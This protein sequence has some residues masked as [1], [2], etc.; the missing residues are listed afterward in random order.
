MRLAFFLLAVALIALP[1]AGDTVLGRIMEARQA[2]DLSVDDYA[3]YCVYSVLAPDRLPSGLTEGAISDPCGTPAI[4]EAEL[5]LDDVS[6]EVRAEI[7]SLLARPSLSGPEYTYDT[8]GGNFKVHYTTSGVDATTLAWAQ[9]LGDGFDWSWEHECD[10][11]GWDEPPSDLGLGGDEKYDIYILQLTGGTLGYTSSSGEPGD[12]TTPENDSASHIAMSNNQSYGQELMSGTC[13]HEF[14]HAIQMGYD[15]AELT[16][17][18]ENCAT[19]MENEC[20]DDYNTYTDHLHSGDNCLRKPWWRIDSGPMYWYG[21]TPWPMYIQNRCAGQASV[22]MTWEEMAA[23][24]TQNTWEALDATADHYG[25]SLAEWVAEYAYWR[26][27]TGP[28]ADD[29]H[30]DYDEASLW[31]PGPYIFYYH[32]VT[33]LPWSGDQG[34]YPPETRGHHWIKVDVSSYQGWITFDFDGRDY[35]DFVI[36]AIRT[37]DSGDEMYQYWNVTEVPATFSVGVETTGYDEVVFVVQAVTQ[38][39]IDQDYVANITYQTGV[40]EGESPAAVSLAP[41]ANPMTA[42][43][44]VEIY[45]PQSGWTT[46]SVFDLTGRLVESIYSGQLDQGQH[47]V[48]WGAEGLSS[49][50]YFLRLFAP[51]GAA[52]SRVV[53]N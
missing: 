4:H 20:W 2:G 25:M 6:A 51:G 9:F 1:A 19:W 36:G 17:F 42:G 45:L 16:W 13:S 8:P 31:T 37:K 29:E 50:T 44:A 48:V 40:E 14:Q 3:L 5:L 39:S 35:M 43:Q 22:R 30:Y 10:D 26:W 28:Q 53:L 46:L 38:T 47:S 12:P 11:M 52:T 33:S 23:V 7:V 15:K 32:N 49:G 24:T 18:M 27:F 34:V 21:A 41:A